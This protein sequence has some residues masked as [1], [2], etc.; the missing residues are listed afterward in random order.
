MLGLNIPT[1]LKPSHSYTYL[2]MKMGQSVPKRWHIKFRRR[3]ITQ[4]KA[5]N[6][7]NMAKV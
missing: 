7:Q 5:H 6:I 1:Y 4:K 2:P 3:G